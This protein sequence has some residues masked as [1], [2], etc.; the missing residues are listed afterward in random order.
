MTIKKYFELVLPSV[1]YYHW[2]YDVAARS[3]MYDKFSL[4]NIY[5]TVI[6]LALVRFPFSVLYCLFII[7]SVDVYNK[8]GRNQF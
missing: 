7:G 6:Y 5:L 1:R 2:C 8:Y 4:T 3:D